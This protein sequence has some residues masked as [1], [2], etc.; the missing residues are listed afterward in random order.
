MTKPDNK[1]L[2]K[3]PDDEEEA[4]V[5]P[6]AVSGGPIGKVIDLTFNPS[7]DKI[8]EVTVIDRM[9]GRLLPQLDT[10]NMVRAYC[11]EVATYR[12]SPEIYKKLFKQLRP[13]SPDIIDELIYRTA[14]WQKSI[15]GRNMEKATDIALAEMEAK[16]DDGDF[17]AN[18]DAYKD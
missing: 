3:R 13:L 11:L 15:G 7:R 2:R 18:I 12:E 1:L 16:A 10:I 6:Q 4:I 8:R 17:G 9:Q 14:Q 5:K